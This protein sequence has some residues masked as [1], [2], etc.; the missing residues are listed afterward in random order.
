VKGTSNGIGVRIAKAI[1]A[2]GAAVIIASNGFQKSNV[3]NACLFFAREKMINKTELKLDWD[4]IRATFEGP[5][6]K[7]SSTTAVLRF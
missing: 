4:K 2:Q 3:M 1:D 5:P 6:V 7:S